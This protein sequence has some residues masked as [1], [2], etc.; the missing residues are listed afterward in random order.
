MGYIG[1]DTTVTI[2]V[3]QFEGL[4][5]LLS[6]LGAHFGRHY[7]QINILPSQKRTFTGYL[8]ILLFTP[9]THEECLLSAFI[10]L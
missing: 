5:E 10:W 3:K 8:Y 4:L 7:W 9:I 6:L 2:D 1:S